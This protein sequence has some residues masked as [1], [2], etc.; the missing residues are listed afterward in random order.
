MSKNRSRHQFCAIE[1]LVLTALA[2]SSGR[3]IAQT[4]DAPVSVCIG[5]EFEV[6]WSGPDG[7][8]DRIAVAEAASSP[9]LSLSEVA[10]SGG[11]PALLTAPS[12]EGFFEIRYVQGNPESILTRRALSVSSCLSSSTGSGSSTSSS[13][14]SGPSPDES[15]QLVT[16]GA[17]RVS[18]VQTNYGDVVSQT[19]AYGNYPGTIDALCDNADTIGWAMGTIVD[20]IDQAMQQAG[21]PITFSMLESLP[22]APSRAGITE[23]LQSV[24][25][26]VCNQPEQPPEVQPFVITYTYCRMTMV[27]PGQLLDIHLP[28]TIGTGTMLAADYQRG[29]A[30]QVTLRRSFEDA[31]V[32]TGPGWSSQVSMTNATDGGNRIGYPTTRYEFEYSGGLGGGLVPMAEMVTTR[33]TGSVWVSD[34]VPGLDIVRTFYRNLT[35]E[36]APD[37]GGM[38]FFAGLIN[39]LVGLLRH[40][41]PLEIDQT[42][43]SSIMGMTTVSGRSRSI[44]SGIEVVDFNDDWCTQV[45][46]PPEIEV[47]DVDQQLSEAMS[48][49]GMSSED[50]AEA[51]E[52]MQ[53]MTPEQRQMLEQMGMG[54]MMQQMMGG[55]TPGAQPAAAAP[56]SMTGG[57]GGSGK[58]NMPSPD[59]L[60]G[61]SVTESVQKHLQALGYDVGDVNGEMSLQT[62]IAIS[63]FQA[64]KGMKVTGEV[65]PQLLGVLSAEVDKRR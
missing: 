42:T 47:Q 37:Q 38:S 21:S 53:N 36:V 13:A 12:L 5:D 3:A 32:V 25:D 7:T 9:A 49:S 50:M 31:A 15:E 14:P 59:E 6:Q 52:A 28:P 39:N 27:T 60:Q 40:G 43:S 19:T 4:L 63:T 1:F 18:G 62:T 41:L 48:Q 55:A 17:V 10:T 35:T 56:S 22:G 65:S 58:V 11:N 61:S 16:G 8:G 64:E 33:N 57:G 46:V 34:Q 54:D 24:R 26:E 20:S 2:I 30:V 23:N 51:M 29:E 44:I 45:L